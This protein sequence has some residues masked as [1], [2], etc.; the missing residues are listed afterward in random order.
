MNKN[1]LKSLL[2]DK[3]EDFEFQDSEISKEVNTFLPKFNKRISEPLKFFGVKNFPELFLMLR[4]RIK[5]A[6]P[7]A[8]NIRFNSTDDLFYIDC[9]DSSYKSFA[10]TEDGKILMVAHG[11]TYPL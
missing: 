2:I 1:K 7:E 11:N 3:V 9:N 5:K 6:F 4:R 8:N 10:I